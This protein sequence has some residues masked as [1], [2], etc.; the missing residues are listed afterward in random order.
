MEVVIQKVS[1]TVVLALMFSTP[2]LSGGVNSSNIPWILSVRTG[3]IRQ[4]RNINDQ[5]LYD[6]SGKVFLY[7]F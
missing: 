7:L 1:I 3:C 6:G 4:V 2:L 5:M